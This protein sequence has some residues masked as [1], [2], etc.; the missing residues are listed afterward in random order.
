[1]KRKSASMEMSL[2]TKRMN[3]VTKNKELGNKKKEI[4]ISG[5]HKS[6]KFSWRFDEDLKEWILETFLKIHMP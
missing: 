3:S 6:S 2:A 4:G 1:M 5:N